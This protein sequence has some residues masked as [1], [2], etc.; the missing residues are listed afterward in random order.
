[1]RVSLC[2]WLAGLLALAAAPGHRA[3]AAPASGAELECLALNVYW[4][5]RS[6]PLEDQL[7]VAFV[8]LNRVEHEAFPASI[9]E[10]V[11][12]GGEGERHKCQFSWWCDGQPDAPTNQQAWSDAMQV[13][14][15]ALSG[16]H[17]DPTGGALYFHHVSVRPEWARRSLPTATIGQHVFYRDYRL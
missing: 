3:D 7:A 1:M 11:R 12:Q 5:S 15:Q 8:T 2:L 10:V 9:C 16:E 17:R 13:A 4:E 6:E 14:R